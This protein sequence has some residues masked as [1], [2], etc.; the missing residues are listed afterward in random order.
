MKIPNE[1]QFQALAAHGRVICNSNDRII[2]GP[3]LDPLQIKYSNL[4]TLG[5]N[6]G[7]QKGENLSTWSLG[8]NPT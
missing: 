6:N 7:Y 1:G 8:A 3:G 2:N 4:K 5:V